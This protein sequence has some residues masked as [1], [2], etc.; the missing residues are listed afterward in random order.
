[1]LVINKNSQQQLSAAV[2]VAGY[3]ASHLRV[4]QYGAFQ[5][6]VGAG[7]T[8]YDLPVAGNPFVFVFP[9]YSITV[10]TLQP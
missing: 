2:N 9:S 1:M 5:D 4:D 3:R 10:L 6:Y 8:T 7:V